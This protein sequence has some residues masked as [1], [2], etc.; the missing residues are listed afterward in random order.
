MHKLKRGA[1][2]F[3]SLFIKVIKMKHKK[4]NTNKTNPKPNQKIIETGKIGASNT[5]TAWVGTVAGLS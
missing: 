1:G 4:Y 5:H 3:F 2:F